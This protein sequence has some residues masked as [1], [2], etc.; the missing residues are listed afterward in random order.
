M[1]E[2]QFDDL[3]RLVQT[4]EVEIA[5]CERTIHALWAELTRRSRAGMV[6]ST[7]YQHLI[8][9]ENE[10]ERWIALRERIRTILAGGGNR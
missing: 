1:S 3:L 5:G 8:G 7:E 2:Q 10:R 6:A 9:A 4:T